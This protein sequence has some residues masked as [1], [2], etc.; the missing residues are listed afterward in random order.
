MEKFLR[1]GCIVNTLASGEKEY[2]PF[3][4]YKKWYKKVRYFVSYYW[5][6]NAGSGIYYLN[7]R[8]YY[9]STNEDAA[10]S[11]LE[12]AIALHERELKRNRDNKII[13]TE[14]KPY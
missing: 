9:T 2:Q 12:E 1:K 13:K 5:S 4:E 6:Q 8:G 7:K 10:M 3:V 14:I 11:K